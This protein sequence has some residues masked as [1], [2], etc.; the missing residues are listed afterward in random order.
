MCARGLF[1][2]HA[3]L[4]AEP[5]PPKKPNVVVVLFDDMRFSDIGAYGGE[6]PTPR[7]DAL[8]SQGLRYTQF[9]NAARCS[10]S[11]AALLTGLYP[12]EAG[13]GHLPATPAWAGWWTT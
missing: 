2:G 4:A 3:V 12:N 10:P 5:A 9:Y 13:M 8:A 7:M 1:G 6:I 11:R